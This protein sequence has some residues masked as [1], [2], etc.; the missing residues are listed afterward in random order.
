MNGN[1]HWTWVVELNVTLSKFFAQTWP[2]LKGSAGEIIK[3]KRRRKNSAR[4]YYFPISF[5]AFRNSFQKP[6]RPTKNAFH[7]NRLI[8]TLDPNKFV[9]MKQKCLHIGK[10]QSFRPRIS[11]LKHS[12]P[13]VGP[14]LCYDQS[15]NLKASARRLYHSY[16]LWDLKAFLYYYMS[17]VR[18]R[19]AGELRLRVASS[20]DPASFESGSDLLLPN[21]RAWTRPLY[22]V[23][24]YYLSLYDKLREDRL[25]P[26][27]LHAYLSTL[28]AKR[29]NLHR[30]RVLYTF[31]DAFIIDFSTSAIFFV[32]TEQ[33]IV[34]L[35]FDKIFYDAREICNYHPYSGAYTNYDL[36]LFQ[37]LLFSW[38]Y[39][40]CLGSIWTFKASRTQRH[41][42]RCYTHYQDNHT[43]E[44]C[45]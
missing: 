3:H 13:V 28:P 17:P 21:G 29:H 2:H 19:I 10:I 39:R 8:V 1:N 40:N 31:N 7:R 14:E 11:L 30:S 33:G 6:G 18:P 23:S 38:I 35:P 36:S 12:T 16:P 15:V 20:D 22:L 45:H 34:K 27:D 26:D 32:L 24:K 9:E 42:D 4:K 37:Y 5:H 44:V 41:K 25:I 43:C